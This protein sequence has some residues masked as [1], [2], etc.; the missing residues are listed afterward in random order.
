MEKC[1]Y[2]QLNDYL[3]NNNLYG[4][5]QSAYRA[6]HSTETTVLKVHNDIMLALDSKRDVILVM[7]DL[8]A[9]FDTIDHTILLQRLE[10]RCGIGGKVLSWIK[11]F[12]SGRTQ[13]VSLGWSM[14][15]EEKQLKFG[16]NCNIC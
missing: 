5:F 2:K 14:V 4:K 10:N 15:S 12:L 3:C 6:G 13:Q 8:S 1:A 7:L 9:A 16:E 11:S